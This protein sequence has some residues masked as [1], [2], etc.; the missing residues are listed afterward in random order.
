MKQKTIQIKNEKVAAAVAKLVAD[1]EAIR[2]F[3]KQGG[4]G[5]ELNERGIKF[6]Q[7]L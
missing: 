1:K 6:E 3:L 4:E 2:S 5:K 7:P